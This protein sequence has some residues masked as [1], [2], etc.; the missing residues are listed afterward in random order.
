MHCAVHL[1]FLYCSLISIDKEL[2]ITFEEIL[3]FATG[4]DSVPPLGFP[5]E[6]EIQ[7]YDQEPGSQRIPYSSTCALVLYL[8]RGITEE[9][10]FKEL[11]LLA[12]K[13][14]FGFGKA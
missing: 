14:S 8:P 9:T 4:A 7:F 13:C 10:D 12:L 3:I 2:D 6:C 1:N 11:M 5:R